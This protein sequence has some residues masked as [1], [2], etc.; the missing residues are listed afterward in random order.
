MALP[1]G[2]TASRSGVLFWVPRADGLG[3]YLAPLRGSGMRSSQESGEVTGFCRIEPALSEVEGNVRPAEA[4]QNQKRRTRM[5]DLGQ[6]PPVFVHSVK[7]NP[8]RMH[9]LCGSD[10]L[11]RVLNL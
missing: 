7:R 2:L 9:R 1:L 3:Y 5:S 8:S 6:H 10:I 11:V 4:K